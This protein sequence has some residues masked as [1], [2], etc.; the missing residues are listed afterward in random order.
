LTA[1]VVFD[2]DGTI[3]DTEEPV[4]RS[5]AELWED[6]GHTLELATWQATIGTDAVFDPWGELEA[7]V[8]R[9]LDPDLHVRRRRRRDE[10]QA[11]FE[12]RAGVLAWLDEATR[13][14]VPVGIASSSPHDW[15]RGHL[16]RLG[17]AV[18]FSC[19]VCC[20]DVVPAKSD[21]TS[22][23][24][25]CTQL[26]ADPR[27]SVAV[28]DS[29]HGVSAAV[30]A[31]LWTVAVPHPLTAGLDLSAADAV[32]GSLSELPLADALDAARRR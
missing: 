15:V 12:P 10:L 17:L 1:C 8:G 3:L 7:R 5:W 4:F 18:M 21:P 16:D 27:C 23:R 28:E 14:G 31:G 2:F 20:D 32:V 24:Q 29:P 22:Y 30:G 13:L 9:T 26:G 19:V 6:H 11:Q 25:A